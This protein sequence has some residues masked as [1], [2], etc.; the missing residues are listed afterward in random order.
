MR[1]ITYRQ[2]DQAVAGV[3]IADAVCPLAAATE[4]A[5]LSQLN[6]VREFLATVEASRRH[7]VGDAAADL[8]GTHSADYP[9]VEEVALLPPVPDPDKIICLALNSKAHCAETGIPEPTVPWFFP[10][11]RTSLVGNNAMMNPP[12]GCAKLDWEGEVALVIGSVAKH[13]T[14]ADALSY[15]AGV[16]P[17]ND[18]SAR[19][20]IHG[21]ET[22]ALTKS[23]DMQAPCGPALVTLDEIGDLNDLRY[24][25]R[26]NGVV[27]Q[28]GST[29]DQVFNAA[30]TLASLTRT[31]TLLPG[32]IVSLGTLQGVGAFSDPPHFMT[33]GDV[34][35]VEVDGV[36]TL[37]TYIG[38]PSREPIVGPVAG[39]CSVNIAGGH[40]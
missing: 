38:S 10:K 14:E 27:K 25:T 30:R 6:S 18:I 34:V 40:R 2:D 23:G 20:F 17:L 29:Q 3:L 22:I 9:R 13:V 11:W 16:M 7:L 1:L 28:D 5:G 19:D 26:L 32:D 31:T 37:R 39:T 8:V 33:A 21:I 24:R 35:E 15:V 36:G 4:H 12:V